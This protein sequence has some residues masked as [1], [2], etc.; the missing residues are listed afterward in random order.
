MCKKK[1]IRIHSRYFRTLL[2]LPIS[3][4][5]TKVKLRAR[6]YFCDNIA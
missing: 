2:D 4:H 1:S 3:G 5:I 6:K